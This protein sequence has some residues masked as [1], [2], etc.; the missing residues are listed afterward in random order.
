MLKQHQTAS[1]YAQ[2]ASNSI[3]LCSSSIKQHHIMLKQHQT[4]SYYAQAASY[5]GSDSHNLGSYKPNLSAVNGRR[6]KI[7]DTREIYPLRKS[8]P[9]ESHHKPSQKTRTP[10]YFCC[11]GFSCKRPNKGTV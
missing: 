2:A 1:Y 9:S 4:A 6:A 8:K 10:Q 3:I 11:E 5:L 7:T